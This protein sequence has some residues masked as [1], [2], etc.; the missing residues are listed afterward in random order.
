M[1]VT[2][3]FGSGNGPQVFS[4]NSPGLGIAADHK[5]LPREVKVD[6][7]AGT[8]CLHDCDPR[9][10][11][12]VQRRC[13]RSAD[14][15]D[16]FGYRAC[17][18]GQ[19]SRSRGDIYLAIHGIGHKSHSLRS[20]KVSL[21]DAAK[22]A[23]YSARVDRSNSSRRVKDRHVRVGLLATTAGA[24]L[25]LV[26]SLIRVTDIIGAQAG[27]SLPDLEA[28]ATLCTAVG[29]ALALAGLT[30]PSWVA[31]SIGANTRIHHYR[32]YRQ[33]ELLWRALVQATPGIVLEPEPDTRAAIAP[34][35]FDFKLRRRV[36]EI[37][38]GELALRPYREVQV[39]AG[40]RPA[41][42]TLS[43]MEQAAYVEAV[44][45]RAAL[46]AKAQDRKGRGSLPDYGL[47]GSGLDDEL[48]W[49]ALLSKTFTQLPPLQG[50]PRAH[51]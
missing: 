31:V 17:Q 12:A 20:F 28:V 37:H 51:P 42:L 9:Q 11:A 43:G 23:A 39:V 3:V 32:A 30:H 49:L 13:P 45:L 14:E 6:A 2:A 15:P 7:D 38:D 10:R 5:G 46:T 4:K 34:R 19:F 1:Q 25:V 50:E 29:A 33:M 27:V 18:Q 24:L 35:D 22:I 8:E 21:H 16:T 36:I 40:A 41:G 26:Y 48:R 44:C 47:V